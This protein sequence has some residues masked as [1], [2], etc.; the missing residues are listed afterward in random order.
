MHELSIV[1][2]ILEIVQGN[3]SSSDESSVK[4]IRVRVGQLCGVLPDS[5][6]FSFTALTTDAGISA[7]HSRTGATGIEEAT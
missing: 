6:E 3:L 1:K 7:L 5:L 4:S 2:S